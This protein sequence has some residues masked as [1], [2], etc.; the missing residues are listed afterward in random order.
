MGL[1]NLLNPQVLRL[2][3]LNMELRLSGFIG[4][5][6]EVMHGTLGKPDPLTF[7]K[8]VHHGQRWHEWHRFNSTGQRQG[9]ATG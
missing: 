3:Q 6:I 5:F 7:A 8:K 9:K 1:A 2:N 4:N